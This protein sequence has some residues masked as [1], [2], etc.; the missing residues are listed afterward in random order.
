MRGRY[1]LHEVAGRGGMAVVWRATQHG[2]AGFCRPV[3]VKQM[4]EHLA[5]SRLYVEMF[6]EEARVLSSIASPNVATIYDFVEDKGQYY[7]VMEWIDGIDLGSYV[8][9]YTSSGRRTRW[10][11]IAA[12]GVGVM[13]ALAAAHERRGPDGEPAP[14]V[15]RDVSPHNI[16]ITGDGM[17]K[18][19]DFGLS[20]ARDR[21]KELTEPGI[22]KGKMSYLS[23]EIVS[24]QRPTPL[25]DQF[26]AGSVLWEALVGRKLFA[27]QTD[28]DVYKKLRDGQVQ[29][30]RPLRRDT[31]RELTAVIHRALSPEASQR[32]P[33]ARE[34]ASHLSQVLRN[35]RAPKDLHEMLGQSAAEARAGVARA[36][37]DEEVSTTTPVA[38]IE[39]EAVERAASGSARRKE[40][41][42]PPAGSRQ[43]ASRD[44]VQAAE[45]SDSEG[46]KRGLL[47]KLPFFWKR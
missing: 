45:R 5:E 8:H 4:H 7:L 10:D 11:L 19:I 32:F 38:D 21:G 30:L 43:R 23:P 27:G 37:H 20:L 41:V 42:T 3:A 22:V 40:E 44:T 35:H 28:Y 46:P 6:A 25:S 17:V 29:P 34:M 16:L 39:L 2:D 33:S 1:E 31:P 18:L 14:I 15:H 24:G 9:Y 47:H 26:A 36:D 12:V 13:R